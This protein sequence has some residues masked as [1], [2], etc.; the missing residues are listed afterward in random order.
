MFQITSGRTKTGFDQ[1]ERM[2]FDIVGDWK[3][4][5]NV[6]YF[7]LLVFTEA[8]LCIAQKKLHDR[9]AVVFLGHNVGQEISE[10]QWKVCKVIL[11]QTKSSLKGKVTGYRHFTQGSMRQRPSLIGRVLWE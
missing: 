2:M 4:Y 1:V 5:K 11:H 7:K 3:S 9:V 10:R 6:N 8:F